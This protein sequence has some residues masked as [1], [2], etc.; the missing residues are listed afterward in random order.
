MAN[1]TLFKSRRVRRVKTADTWN[2]QYAPAY[3]L[4]PRHALAQYAA[5]GCLSTTYYADDEEQ[6][7]MV[8][9][10]CDEVSADFIAKTAI[11]A[12]QKGYMKDMPALLCARLSVEAP[13]LL[14]HIFHRVIDN[15]RMVRN[16]VQIMRSGQAGRNSLG[17]LPKRLVKEWFEYRSDEAIF[18]ASVGK[19][20]SIAD[21]IKMVHPRPK[22]ASREAL[23]G[24]LIGRR[25]NTEV[26]PKLVQD[27][28]RYKRGNMREV[29][30]VPFQML[31]S[32]NLGTREWT[33][34][35]K[36]AS[37]HMT[38]MNLNTFLRH[39]VLKNRRMVRLIA[40]RLK[41]RELIAR[42]R[43]FPYQLM[44]AYR[45]VGRVPSKITNAL[46]AAMDIA[47][48]NIPQVESQV[49]V[50]PDV[51]G[52]MTWTSATGDRDTATSAVRCI[53]VAALISAA[54]LRKNPDAEVLPFS[55]AVHRCR[56]NAYDSVMRNA[57]KLSDLGG[58][59]TDITAPLKELNR[60][61]AKG[62]LV[63]FVSDNESW[64]DAGDGS[65]GTA[66][67]RHWEDFKKR[68][69]RAKLICLDIQPNRTA[70]A[71]DRDDILNIGG[72]SDAV[73][74]LIAN[75]AVGRMSDGHWVAE[76]DSIEI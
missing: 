49:Y 5:T 19:S 7:D 13:E 4:S 29:P 12:R 60:R 71:Y 53:D 62:D 3:K 30:D 67:M 6:L 66:M 69:P 18:R 42:S 34:I 36:S 61:K 52:S 31:T 21:I 50:C 9:S 27:F 37:W 39:G 40:D 55:I 33:E 74:R 63:I 72:F 68:N 43:V 8:M 24:Y 48:E 32:Q 51:S 70:Q 23:Y 2:A 44:M 25:V 59:A 38:R 65:T 17:T 1:K 57:E 64:V 35:A 41:D 20:P 16:F 56:L 11:W 22:T 47:I 28:E 73:F 45:A 15:G 58:G 76:I 46:Q 75:F 10:L 26:L 54:L 14:D